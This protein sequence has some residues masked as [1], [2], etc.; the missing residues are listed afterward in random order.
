MI[1]LHMISTFPA[2]FGGFP[3]WRNH[4]YNKRLA[5]AVI[6]HARGGR[7]LDARVHRAVPMG[8]ERQGS[9]SSLHDC[10]D[11]IVEDLAC[12]AQCGRQGLP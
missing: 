6:V 12:V 4:T 2:C 5:P 7:L 10:I 11:P 1:L 3:K 8:A 9:S